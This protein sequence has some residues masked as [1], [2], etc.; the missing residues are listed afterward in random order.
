MLIEIPWLIT[1]YD[2][3][4]TS[5]KGKRAKK[6]GP[7]RPSSAYILFSKDAREAIKE[8]QPDLTFGEIGKEIG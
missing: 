2:G 8:E 3:P 5:S 4:S 1:S 6:K 7:K